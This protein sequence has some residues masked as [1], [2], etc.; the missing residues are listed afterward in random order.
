[1]QGAPIACQ[2]FGIII[3]CFDEG[4]GR[5][6]SLPVEDQVFPQGTQLLKIGQD[7]GGVGFLSAT[8]AACLADRP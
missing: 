2:F 1:V 8:Y 3:N 7:G 6:A 4:I 5:D